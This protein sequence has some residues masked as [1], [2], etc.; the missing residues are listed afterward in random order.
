M[1]DIRVTKGTN[2]AH[3]GVSRNN[4]PPEFAPFNATKEKVLLLCCVFVWV[5]HSNTSQLRQCFYLQDTCAVTV[6][7]C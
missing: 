3:Q 5:H 1:Q 6:N 4:W 7:S 2:N